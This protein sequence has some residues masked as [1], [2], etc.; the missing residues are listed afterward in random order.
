M[1]ERGCHV[2]QNVP[3]CLGREDAF[4]QPAR[5]RCCVTQVQVWVSDRPSTKLKASRLRLQFVARDD[6]SSSCWSSFQSQ[7]QSQSHS[8]SHSHLP[9]LAISCPQDQSERPHVFVVRSTLLFPISPAP[10]RWFETAQQRRYM[11]K[12]I[13]SAPLAAD[14]A[15]PSWPAYLGNCACSLRANAKRS[16]SY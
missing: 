14:T 1:R 12:H 6:I 5:L 11:Y 4:R 15:T 8:H 2:N 10:H 9:V 3:Q 13:P 7:S 16:V